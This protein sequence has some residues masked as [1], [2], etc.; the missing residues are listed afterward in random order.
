MISSVRVDIMKNSNDQ[1]DTNRHPDYDALTAI[2]D[3]FA[4]PLYKFAL[5]IC[6]DR[7]EGDRIVGDVFAQL[8]EQ[9][10]NGE[11][12]RS[13]LRIYLYQNA[14]RYSLKFLLD[15]PNEP[16]REDVRGAS[17][18]SSPENPGDKQA[19]MEALKRELTEDQRHVLILLFL[20]DFSIDE[21]AE[22][23]GKDVDA[24]L[25]CLRE[26]QKIS[27]HHPELRLDLAL[28]LKR[29]KRKRK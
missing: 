12:H 21:T 13:N 25:T 7:I 14:Y 27:Q 20:E 6:H 22:I 10:G 17:E 8:L 18:K 23:L 11:Q 16:S 1:A 5:R 29:K 2:F 3:E 28:F 9:W 24:I 19:V 26:I 15:Y 4:A